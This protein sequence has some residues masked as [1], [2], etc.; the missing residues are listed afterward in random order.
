MGSQTTPAQTTDA[1]QKA[2]ARAA[3]RASPKVAEVLTRGVRIRVAELV[4]RVAQDAADGGM[5]ELSE[6]E[7]KKLGNPVVAH[8]LL[9]GYTPEKYGTG[10][11]LGRSTARAVAKAFEAARKS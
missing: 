3:A 4:Q 2:R 5:T 11:W 9:I 6:A 10:R 8:G 7:A 1:A